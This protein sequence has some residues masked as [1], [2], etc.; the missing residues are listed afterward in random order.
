MQL[1]VHIFAHR[2][3]PGHYEKGWMTETFFSGGT[4]PS[5]DL[6]LHFQEVCGGVT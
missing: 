5:A 4:L 3:V 6:L 1:F 2:E